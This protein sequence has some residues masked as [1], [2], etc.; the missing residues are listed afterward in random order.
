LPGG[1]RIIVCGGVILE[2]CPVRFIGGVGL[3][4]SRQLFSLSVSAESTLDLGGGCFLSSGLSL[5]FL[6]RE[7]PSSTSLPRLAFSF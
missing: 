7:A 4:F 5:S 1:D 3:K 2:I 6:F